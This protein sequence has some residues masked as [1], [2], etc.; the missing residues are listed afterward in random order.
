MPPPTLCEFVLHTVVDPDGRVPTVLGRDAADVVTPDRRLS[1]AAL[2]LLV[3]ARPDADPDDPDLV[4][5]VRRLNDG[6]AQFD[7]PK[8]G[9]YHELLDADGAPHPVGAIRTPAIQALAH[10]A[11]YRAATVLVACRL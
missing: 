9:G 7:D 2:A 10:W 3:V 8:A 5:T 1:D 4:T 11:R 6:L